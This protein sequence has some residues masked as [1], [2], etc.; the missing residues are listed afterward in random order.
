LIQELLDVGKMEAGRPLGIR[1][2]FHDVRSIAEEAYESAQLA[3]ARKSIQ[4]TS[5]VA[6]DVTTV[7]ADR[8]RVLQVLS[9]LIDNAMKFTPE[10]GQITMTCSLLNDDVRFEVSDT[11]I[12]IAPEDQPRIFEVYRQV[13]RTHHPGV[14][15]GLA[16]AKR[17][18]EEH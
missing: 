6:N 2:E 18:I 4:F 15:L 13:G 11:G 5:E 8:Q 10:G 12:G 3:A 17:I 1:P 7:Y 16:I 14:G 9:N